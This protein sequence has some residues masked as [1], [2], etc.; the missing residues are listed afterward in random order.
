MDYGGAEG[1]KPGV[2][3]ASDSDSQAITATDPLAR[4]T[5]IGHS[6]S[7]SAQGEPRIDLAK[8]RLSAQRVFWLTFLVLTVGG[9]VLGSVQHGPVV[10]GIILFLALP[11]VQLG[12]IL[13][14]GIILAVTT[15]PDNRYPFRQLGKIFEGTL[16]GAFLGAL[17]MAG[18]GLLF[19]LR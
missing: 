13:V 16:A 18:I 19:A 11:G 12:A 7:T 10:T 6:N 17:A 8:S 9:M 1:Y 5:P 15:P 3:A 14:T 4:A 2:Q